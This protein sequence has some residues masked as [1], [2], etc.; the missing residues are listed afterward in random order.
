MIQARIEQRNATNQRVFILPASFDPLEML[1]PKLHKF[2]DDARYV[3]STILRKMARGQTDDYG[4]VALKAEYLTQIISERRCKEIVESLLAA[5]AVRRR[6]YQ[7]GVR[8]FSYR[9]A[10][11][12]Q[13]DR[14]IRLPIENK[15]LL[16]N[17]ERH[18]AVCREEADRRLKPVHH[19]LVILQNDLQIDGAE[20]KAILHTLPA[21]SNPFD[22]QGVLIQD[23]LDRRFRLCV[24]K[25]GRVTN[26]ITSMKREI[27]SALRCAGMPLAGVDISCAQPCLLSLLIRIL[28][29]NVGSYIATPPVALPAVLPPCCPSV[30]L[31]E[32][33]CLSGGLFDV[34]GMRLRDAGVVWSRNEVK[35][36][37][38]T[39][40]LA[41]K[42][43]STAGAEYPS[44]IEDVFRAEFPGV[45]KF[46]RAVNEDGWEHA[47]L[48]RLLQQLEA[49]L[50]IEQVCGRFVQRY[51]GEFLISLHDAVYCRPEML[52]ALADS[53]EQ[54]FS[55]LDFRPTLKV[56]GP[57]RDDQQDD[58][59]QRKVSELRGS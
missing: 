38:L 41:K 43:A 7:K 45:W 59:R 25:Y 49:W 13:A 54:V 47:R 28:Q 55:E 37:F 29:K 27:R 46:I 31:F 21:E 42:K 18:E 11:Q 9:L 39:D 40:V 23:I 35:K 22:V 52:G 32:T 5:G 26:S 4:Y 20:S 58:R 10:D 36:R 56:E 6:P 34:L 33:V 19:T 12:Y 30:V 51:P 24:G 57:D 17:L 14:H 53:F 16:R 3:I 44:A 1:R 48:I 15:R 8:S 50:V 2:A